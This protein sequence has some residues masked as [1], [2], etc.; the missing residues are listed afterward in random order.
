M[1][2]RLK[3][4]QA[5]VHDP[6]LLLLDEPT[7][8]LDPKGREQMLRPQLLTLDDIFVDATALGA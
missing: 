7:N 5:V 3:L 2:Q 6:E 8:G 4:A 1:K